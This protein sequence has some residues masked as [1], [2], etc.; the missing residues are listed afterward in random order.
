MYQ[1]DPDPAE[2]QMHL[3]IRPIQARQNGKSIRA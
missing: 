2:R 1:P 3:G